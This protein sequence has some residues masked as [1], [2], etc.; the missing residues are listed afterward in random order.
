M[1]D[2]KHSLSRETCKDAAY[3][4]NCEDENC[5]PDCA[6]TA[7][8]AASCTNTMSADG[9]TACVFTAAAHIDAWALGYE[10]AD[11]EACSSANKDDSGSSHLAGGATCKLKCRDGFHVQVRGTVPAYRRVA[12]CGGPK[13]SQTLAWG[14]AE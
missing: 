9:V 13:R 3:D 6:Y 7:G 1:D 5:L 8:D 10:P 2:N 14:G 4:H 12:Q 11:A